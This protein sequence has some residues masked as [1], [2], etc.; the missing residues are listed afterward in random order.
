MA[1]KEG[2]QTGAKLYFLRTRF[3]ER[4]KLANHSNN[5]FHQPLLG[6]LVV[7]REAWKNS[8][9]PIV[10]FP[11]RISNLQC[12]GVRD[13]TGHDYV[14]RVRAVE[15]VSQ[16]RRQWSSTSYVR[17]SRILALSPIRPSF[18]VASVIVCPTKFRSETKPCVVRDFPETW[19][20]KL[21][22]NSLELTDIQRNVLSH[23][24]QCLVLSCEKVVPT[25][26]KAGEV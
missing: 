12:E 20:F 25:L 15:W 1:W 18:K 14:K 16:R 23:L 26:L 2:S 17:M 19:I 9:S 6:V 7:N 11:F 8:Q 10:F 24:Q 21:N 13:V 4:T 22:C 5:S 3:L